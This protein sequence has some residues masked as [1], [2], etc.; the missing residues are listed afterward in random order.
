MSGRATAD[1]AA[2]SGAPLVVGVDTGGTKTAFALAD[3]VSGAVL[4]ER[5]VSSDGWQT[6]SL[7]DAAA[8][9]GS[10]VREVTAGAGRPVAAVTVGAH[11]CE[12]PEQCGRLAES[13]RALLDVPVAVLNDAELLVPAAGFAHGVGVVAGTGSIAVGRHA[14]T[15]A[16]LKAGGWG[17]VLGDEGSGSA[18]VRDAA[19]SVLRAADAAGPPG[20]APGDGGGDGAG[21]G[22]VDPLAAVL[23]ASF[24]QPGLDELA[25][26]MSWDGGV[27]TW[28]AHAPA[29]FAAADAGSP[30]ARGVIADGGRALARLVARLA[31]RGARVDAVVAAGG[32]IGRQ[33]RLYDAFAASLGEL[34]PGVAPVLLEAAPVRGAIALALPLALPLVR[35]GGR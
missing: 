32:V 10:R 8:W 7:R 14:E 4:D 5:T 2:P 6:R 18:L 20:D 35:S 25:A 28:G 16:Y 31:E 1:G 3:A 26:A 30:L 22:D 33:P 12:S 27:E 21:R 13:L 24:A 23:L 29:V 19:R 9:L 15:G 11:G 34:L 17:W